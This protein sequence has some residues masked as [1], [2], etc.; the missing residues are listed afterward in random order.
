M[1]IPLYAFL[2]L[3]VRRSRFSSVYATPVQTLSALSFWCSRSHSLWGL[4]FTIREE[5]RRKTPCLT[6]T[7]THTHIHTHTHTHTH[8]VILLLV[9]SLSISLCLLCMLSTALCLC[10][11]EPLSHV[12]GTHESD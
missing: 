11:I 7:H 9:F 2:T 3:Y 10:A 4:H 5:I 1:H 6:H 8:S 12:L